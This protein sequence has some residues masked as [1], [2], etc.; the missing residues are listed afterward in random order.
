MTSYDDDLPTPQEE[1]LLK[2]LVQNGEE[3]QRI[4]AIIEVSKKSR[5]DVLENSSFRPL[6]LS[7]LE[8]LFYRASVATIAGRPNSYSLIA[9]VCILSFRLKI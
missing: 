9:I 5:L 6:I 2:Q 3:V 1:I 8:G 7:C 4:R